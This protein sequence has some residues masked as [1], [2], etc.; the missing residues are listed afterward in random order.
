MRIY[1][2]GIGGIGMSGLAQAVL[3]RGADVCGSD[4]HP[5]PI[6]RRLQASGA[7]V[8]AGHS[9]QNL[10]CEKPDLVVAS[11]AIKADN[12]EIAAARDAGIPLMSRA[13]FLGELMEKYSG[14]RVAVAGT[15]GKTTTTAMAAL[16]L[17]EGG[18]DPT[19]LVGGDVA[20]FGGNVRVGGGEA[21]V[22]EACE[23]F[24][25]FLHIPGHIR[26][27]TNIEP[28]HLDYFGS[29]ERLYQSFR[30]FALG[31][32]VGGGG[33]VVA[34]SDDAGA[35]GLAASL[36]GEC[37]LVLYGLD[38][39]EARGATLACA[40]AL[41]ARN[42][43]L[44]RAGSSF[45]AVRLVEGSVQD[46]ACVELHVPGVH[47]VR[48]GLAALA[49]GIEAGVPMDVAARALG[50]FSGVERRFEVLG[51]AGEVVV[52]DDYAHHPTEISATLAAARQ[53][54]PHR[55]I[56]AVFQPHLYSRTRD[57]MEGFADVL[58]GFDAVIITE[59]YAAREE[60]IP[61]V[62]SRLLVQRLA[63][64][65]PEKTV[66]YASGLA[67]AAATLREIT[68]DGD[69]VLTIGAGD[70]REVGIT[71]LGHRVRDRA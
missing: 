45:E 19:V 42:V 46:R 40:Y 60:P 66:L 36:G 4:A 54:Y 24:D 65:A 6:T 26:I 55:R 38:A 53:V 58:A 31:R 32:R 11:S 20:L 33:C 63:E 69:V 25:S 64:R 2:I 21:F 22:T 9:A 50:R 49:A 48:N 70:V 68:R 27:I 37:R 3:E 61:G 12:P 62:S 18:L 43:T 44:S 8:Y 10:L 39:S 17:M 7:R 14:P 41:A 59:I 29:V 57:F 30:A 1:F 34:C 28:D 71:Y 56:V 35:L 15:H 51:E 52:V 47:N 16:V 13:E 23:A 67:D 5:S